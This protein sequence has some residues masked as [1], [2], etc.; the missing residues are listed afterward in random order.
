MGVRSVE[1]EQTRVSLP[2]QARQSGDERPTAVSTEGRNAI[3][4]SRVVLAVIGDSSVPSLRL[5]IETNLCYNTLAVPCPISRG[6]FGGQASGATG[7]F[8]IC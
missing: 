7:G 2:D 4:P 8:S 1:S 6:F 3:S 5:A